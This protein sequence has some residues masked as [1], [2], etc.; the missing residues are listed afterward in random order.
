MKNDSKAKAN[1]RSVL[2]NLELGSLK[3]EEDDCNDNQQSYYAKD[4]WITY[5]Y[6]YY[7]GWH[8]REQKENKKWRFWIG[9]KLNKKQYDLPI[10]KKHQELKPEYDKG[11]TVKIRFAH[12]ERFTPMLREKFPILRTHWIGAY[13]ETPN[14]AKLTVSQKNE[15][16]DLI[17]QLKKIEDSLKPQV[18]IKK[19]GTPKIKYIRRLSGVPSEILPLHNE[20][21]KKFTNYL[22]KKKNIRLGKPGI[23]YID[24]TYTI[25]KIDV[26]CELKP[27]ANTANIRYAIG[28]LL[29][30]RCKYKGKNKNTR[31]QIVVGK[32][33]GESDIAILRSIQDEIPIALT[34]WNQKER[35]FYDILDLVI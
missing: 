3:I 13:L 30:Y 4:K 22:S 20:L 1:F 15:I 34:Y 2:N 29:D 18:P 19:G 31:L 21:E 28:Q 16:A 32:K 12:E 26:L 7:R 6:Q 11:Y 27:E 25:N 17:I 33:P 8:G 35:K 24:L 10:I 5:Y 23:D 14:P 9:L